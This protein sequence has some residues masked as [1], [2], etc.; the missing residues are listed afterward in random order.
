ME[1]Y[2]LRKDFN[3]TIEV[4]KNIVDLRLGP[5]TGEDAYMFAEWAEEVLRELNEM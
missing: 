4:L 1:C 2:Y 3:K 5:L